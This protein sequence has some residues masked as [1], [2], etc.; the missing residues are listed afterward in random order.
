[1][2]TQAEFKDA[3]VLA[4]LQQ[5]GL[6]VGVIGLVAGIGGAMI[7][8]D[9]FVHSWLIGFLFCLGLTLG[10]L[11]LLMLQHLSG[12]QWGLVSRRIFEAGTRNLPLVA[13]FF[14]PILFWLP[15][16]FEWARP[17][18]GRERDHPGQGRLP[19][20]AVLHHPRRHLLR[21]LDAV[22]LPAQQVVGRAGSRHRHDA[23]RQRPLPQGERAGPP[24][25]GADGDL[26][27]GRLGHVAR[28]RVVLDHLRPADDR[29][30]GPDDVRVDDRGAVHARAHRRD[31][32]ACSSRGTSTISAS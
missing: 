30:L 19:Q 32:A 22:H 3:P 27:V 21:L 5:R 17:G 15:T 31:R 23:G 14:V 11:A 6:I 4:S 18:G 13:L 20:P 8:F 24:V 7:S 10:S 25:P 28:P 1:M 2:A 29:R 16:I 12:G 26:R 9:Q